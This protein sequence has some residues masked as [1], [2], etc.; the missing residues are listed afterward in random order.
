MT[1]APRTRLILLRH[2]PSLSLGTQCG[3]SD[4][5]AD[6]R[7]VSPHPIIINE[8]GPIHRFVISPALRCRQTVDALWPE[9][10]P[11]SAIVEDFRL[12][13]QDF[14]DW[15]G[16]PWSEIPDLGVLDGTRLEQFRPPNGESFREVCERVQPAITEILQAS[17]GKNV[18]VCAHAGPI[19]A[20][21]A[22]ALRLSAGEALRFSIANLSLTVV[23]WLAPEL[24]SVELVNGRID[25]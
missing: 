6:C 18:F 4:V 1:D 13:E 12:W 9:K 10:G 7:S 19:R 8:W 22:M 23:D 16:L 25:R 21:L 17:I 15:E 24:W 11:D 3:R 14:G 20:V 5:P 2:A